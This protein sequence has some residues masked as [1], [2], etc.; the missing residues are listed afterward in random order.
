MIYSNPRKLT[1][2]SSTLF[3]TW[4]GGLSVLVPGMARRYLHPE[5]LFSLRSQS[6]SNFL[7]SPA[8]C[9]LASISMRSVWK[10]SY[11]LLFLQHDVGRF[12]CIRVDAE[13]SLCF[14]AVADAKQTSV[15]SSTWALIRIFYKFEIMC[16]CKHFFYWVSDL[17]HKGVSIAEW[18]T[19]AFKSG[20]RRHWNGRRRK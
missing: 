18:S 12:R 7:Y 13:A 2:W 3:V 10:W 19:G 14:L 16:C 20:L 1:S 6:R 5:Y 11:K 8:L 15:P 17:W 9:L 4:L